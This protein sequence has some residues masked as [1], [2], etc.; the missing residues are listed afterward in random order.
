ML[1]RSKK[2]YVDDSPV[3]GRGVFASEPIKK[4]EILE[5]CHFFLLPKDSS[6][7]QILNDHFFS[8]PKRTTES[9]AICLGYGSIFNHSDNEFNADWETDTQKNKFIFFAIRDIQEGEEIFTNYQ[10]SGKI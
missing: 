9:F 5:E 3:H 8:W 6:Y 4:G 2:I 1:Y 7:E 10:K